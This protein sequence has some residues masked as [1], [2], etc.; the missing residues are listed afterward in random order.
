[1]DH[2]LI[3]T[4]LNLLFHRYGLLRGTLRAPAL[5]WMMYNILVSNEKSIQSQYK[6]HVYADPENVTPSIIESRY[7]LTKRKGARYVP[8][9]FL[10]GLLDPVKSREEFI[11]LFPALEGRIPVLI[12]STRNAPKRSKAE[13]EALR[14]AKGVSKF[15]EVVGALLP[16]EEY[17]NIIAE[18]LHKF[19]QEI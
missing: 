10:T 19:L 7:E 8:A 5:G 13:M 4:T 15:I 1:M 2:K 17:P 9:A 18:E 6:S 16:Q 3:I 14:E 11:E 12:V